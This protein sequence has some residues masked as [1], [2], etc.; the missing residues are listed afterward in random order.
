MKMFQTHAFFPPPGR[1]NSVES[2]SQLAPTPQTAT[3][4][5]QPLWFTSWTRS[6]APAAAGTTVGWR[7]RGTKPR[8][9]ASGCWVSFAA[10]LRCC[11]LYPRPSDLLWCS[12]WVDAPDICRGLVATCGLLM[13]DC[14]DFRWC[15]AS[16]CSSRPVERATCTCSTCA[17][18]PSAA[19]PSAGAC[20]LSNRI[21]SP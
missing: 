10:T 18:W 11:R 21:S 7:T 5:R 9:A 6:S 14:C 2:A 19:T 3:P 17:R 13:L 8:Q 1:Q 20:C 16:T 12:R 15:P 4:T